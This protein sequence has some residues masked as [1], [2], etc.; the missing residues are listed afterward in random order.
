MLA[1][2]SKKTVLR[3]ASIAA[4]F[5][6]VLL[7][8]GSIVDLTHFSRFSSEHK[9]ATAQSATEALAKKVPLEMPV[10]QAEALIRSKGFTADETGSA[11]LAYGE[12]H[13]GFNA[14]S[15]QIS[16]SY[17][18]SLTITAIGTPSRACGAL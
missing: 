17:D 18:M 11:V 9:L 7:V 1:M 13:E 6:A 3:T 14:C 12:V 4:G 10:K 15:F 16:F 8:L 5:T 2:V